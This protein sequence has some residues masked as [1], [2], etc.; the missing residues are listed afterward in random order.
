MPQTKQIVGANDKKDMTLQTVFDKIFGSE[1][2]GATQLDDVTYGM[3]TT[4]IKSDIIVGALRNIFLV[5]EICRNFTTLAPPGK[6]TYIN[7]R[8]RNN[9]IIHISLV[10]CILNFNMYSL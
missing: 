6:L 7:T 8:C 9:G 5:C 2:N 1:V 10:L 3:S 4:D